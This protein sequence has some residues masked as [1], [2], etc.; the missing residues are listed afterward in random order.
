M[1]AAVRHTVNP[2]IHAPLHAGIHKRIIGWVVGPG[3]QLHC[4]YW[5]LIGTLPE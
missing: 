5:A 3:Y 1:E 4:S 2:Y